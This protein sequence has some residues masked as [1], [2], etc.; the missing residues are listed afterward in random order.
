MT[1]KHNF[2]QVSSLFFLMGIP[3]VT[4]IIGELSDISCWATVLLDVVNIFAGPLI[5]LVLIVR[6]EIWVS[7]K[8][9]IKRRAEEFSRGT[10]NIVM[11]TLAREI[12][13][14]HK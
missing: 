11:T 14:T 3:W 6:K 8:N 2:R 9:I 5:F 4:E 10:D 7:L 12:I 1:N 13:S